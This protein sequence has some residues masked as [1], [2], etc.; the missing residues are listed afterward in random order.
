MIPSFCSGNR[1]R[2][3]RRLSIL[4][5]KKSFRERSLKEIK[6]KKPKKKNKKK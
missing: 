6:D 1:G 4:K 5:I 2:A 3:R